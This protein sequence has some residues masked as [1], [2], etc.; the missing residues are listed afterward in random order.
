MAERV[1]DLQLKGLKI[2]QNPEAFCFGIDAVLLAN[3]VR[4]KPRDRVMDLGTGNGIIP[5]LLAGKSTTAAI[6]AIELQEDMADMAR[7]S[8]DLNDLSRRIT[9]HTGDIRSIPE[10]HEKSVYDVVTG[11]P[12]YMHCKG[13]I[14]PKEKKAIARHEVACDLE[15]V[16]RGA[17]SLL[18]THGRLYLVHRPNRLADLL[19]LMK[20]YR[21]EPKALTFVQP[22][23]N[24]PP[25][26][27][28][29]EG[30]KG[31][32]PE[33]T[34][35]KP[36]IIYQDNGEY[37]REVLA[38]YQQENIEWGHSNEKKQEQ[39]ESRRNR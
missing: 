6:E 13:L 19:A 36:L 1:D 30:K 7:R 10:E 31:A 39:E 17:E 37:T 11:N 5:L 24:K 25:N 33:M 38:L 21:I 26:L 29:V 14:N 18:R 8:V 4:L 35:H 34:V 32:N 12:P 20:A 16:I 3:Q 15:D 2:I 9:I 23:M 28:L 27:I 22:K